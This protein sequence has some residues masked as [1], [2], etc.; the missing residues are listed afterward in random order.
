MES[1][2]W[3]EIQKLQKGDKWEILAKRLLAANQLGI[4]I[5]SADGHRWLVTG[6]P[7]Q[8]TSTCEASSELME[9]NF[10]ATLQEQGIFVNNKVYGSFSEALDI[11][12]TA[13]R[14]YNGNKKGLL[15]IFNEDVSNNFEGEKDSPEDEQRLLFDPASKETLMSRVTLTARGSGGVI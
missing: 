11:I 15:D 5:K 10:N 3:D 13:L 6:C 1:S 9:S 2:I 8:Q 7:P 4:Y 12:E 14:K